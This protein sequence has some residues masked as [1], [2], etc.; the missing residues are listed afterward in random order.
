MSN[1]SA[2]CWSRRRFVKILTAAGAMCLGAGNNPAAAPARPSSTA[3]PDSAVRDAMD[4]ARDFERDYSSDI[5]IRDADLTLLESALARLTRLQYLVGHANFNLL[6]FDLALRYAR[7]YSRV[8]EFTAPELA[9]IEQLF[10]TDARRYGFFGEKTAQRLTENIAQRDVLKVGGSGHYIY[11]GEA[12]R[13]YKLIRRDI[14]EELELT[15]GIRSVVKQLHL[16][17]AKAATTGGNLSRA[18]RQLAPP[19]HS[20]H[21][22][23]DFDVGQ[24]GLGA[25]NF[26]EH[27]ARSEVYQRMQELG[28]ARMR[29]PQANPF[30]VRYEPWHIE[31][32]SHA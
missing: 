26:T 24:R 14:G 16:F 25:A 20:F 18:A 4:R 28:Y 29:Y 13:I 22:I 32:V 1:I 21:G 30:G 15:S 2:A 3:V 17:L 23:G 12:L 31:V 6:G 8:G 19:G 9:F 10:I 7:N 27:F 11:R 5:F